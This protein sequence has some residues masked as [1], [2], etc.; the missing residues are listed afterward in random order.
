M[1]SFP[2]AA[3]AYLE[4]GIS[5]LGEEPW[6]ADYHLVLHLF[7]KAAY[8]HHA[9]GE[10]ELMRAR[11]DAVFRN[12]VCFDDQLESLNVLIQSMSLDANN[13]SN[14][15]EK[16]CW[17]LEQLGESFPSTTDDASIV[18]DLLEVKHLLERQVQVSGALS[19]LPPMVNP[20]KIQAMVS[21][22]VRQ[23]WS[24]PVHACTHVTPSCR[25]NG[26]ASSRRCS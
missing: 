18:R 9:K 3:C 19:N 26:R 24:S 14:A 25:C 7:K 4:S 1:S 20:Q 15:F 12:A 5:F 16:S 6:S 17:V 22:G 10:T 21:A 11:L 2:H 13:L 8:V 23:R